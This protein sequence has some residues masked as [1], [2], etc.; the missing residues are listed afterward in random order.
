MVRTRTPLVIL[1]LAAGCAVNPATGKHQLALVS[2]S[3]EIGMGKEAAAEVAQSVGIYADARLNRYVAEVG[4]R[5]AAASERPDL[6]WSFQ[7]VDD[8]AVNAFALPG[9]PVFVTR[10]LLAHLENEAQLATVIGHE[11]GHV[12]AK[13][14]VSRISKAE[15]AQLGLGVGMIF[16]DTARQLGQAELAAM[17]VLFLKFSRDDE[18]QADELGLRYAY[19][20][21]YDV[22]EMPEVFATLKR[23]SDEGQGSR[24]PEWL[25]THPDPEN[26]VEKTEARLKKL[27]IQGPLAVNT[28]PYLKVIDGMEFGPDP[29]QGFFRGQRFLHPGLAFTVT[30]PAG[31]QRAN[32]K[33]AVTAVSP[34]QDAIM[35]ITVAKGSDPQQAL[36][37]FLSQPGVQAGHTGRTG[38]GLPSAAGEFAAETEQG[39]LAG[40]VAFISNRGKLYQVLTATAA[41]QLAQYAPAFTA[42]SASFAPLTDPAVL[43]VQPARLH[44]LRAPRTMTLAELYR[45]RPPSVPL[46]TV[47]VVNQMEPGTT[48]QAGAPVKWVSGGTPEALGALEPSR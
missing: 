37:T 6:P 35:Q 23:V 45:E 17:Q 15:L 18:N 24:V 27:P 46:A 26:R 1:A 21:K 4:H 14:A 33:E 22:R 25:A 19:R 38:S 31:W 32:L 39:A 11:I 42:V 9:G 29:R 40:V 10:G 13:H 43:G 44:V 2:Q 12:T 48:L 30:F 47:A 7:V 34:D 5:L 36:T 8:A 41:A 3:Q 16:S 28:E 20:T